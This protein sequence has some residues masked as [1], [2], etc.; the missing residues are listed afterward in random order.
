MIISHVFVTVNSNYELEVRSNMKTR[1]HWV[2]V[3]KPWPCADG[4]YEP[5]I[6]TSEDDLNFVELLGI[7]KNWLAEP[8]AAKRT[9]FDAMAELSIPLGRNK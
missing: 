9:I 6:V 2:Q 7:L 1:L 3:R 5:P 4:I 8:E